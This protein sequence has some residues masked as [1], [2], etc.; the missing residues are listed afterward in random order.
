MCSCFALPHTRSRPISASL[1]ELP[2]P[3][4]ITS[5][6][7]VLSLRSNMARRQRWCQVCC[8][9]RSTFTRCCDVCRRGVNP[10]C[11]PE[12]CLAQDGCWDEPPQRRT[13]C[14]DCFVSMSQAILPL[15]AVLPDALL[16]VVRN[17]TGN[18]RYGAQTAIELASASY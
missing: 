12:H 9:H 14:K 11:F 15:A 3:S 13:L 4:E 8:A 16:I 2:P 1:F 6:C 10:G 17:N 5:A 7:R 18:H